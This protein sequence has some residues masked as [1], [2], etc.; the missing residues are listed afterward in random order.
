VPISER[1]DTLII[2]LTGE[3]SNLADRRT[4]LSYEFVTDTLVIN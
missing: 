1:Y 4:V 3:Q 2:D